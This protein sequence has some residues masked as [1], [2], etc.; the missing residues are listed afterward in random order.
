[1]HARAQTYLSMLCALRWSI[2][3]FFAGMVAIMTVTVYLLY[4][5]TKSLPIEEA[6]HVF[7]NHWCA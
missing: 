5:E 3:L 2:F 6:P 7:A 1:M 4:P